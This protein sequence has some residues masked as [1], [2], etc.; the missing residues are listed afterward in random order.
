MELFPLTTIGEATCEAIRSATISSVT[1][2]VRADRLLYTV[3]CD[4]SILV[5]KNAGNTPVS[6][7]ISLCL[8]A[9]YDV[10]HFR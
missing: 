5:H 1:R 7:D 6:S 3:H 10:R 9:F 4:D 8:S 2:R